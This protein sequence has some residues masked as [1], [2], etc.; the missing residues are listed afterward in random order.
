MKQ[1][2]IGY[3]FRSRVEGKV[4]GEYLFTGFLFPG[5]HLTDKIGHLQIRIKLSHK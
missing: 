1:N 3:N 2:G 4:A 5:E